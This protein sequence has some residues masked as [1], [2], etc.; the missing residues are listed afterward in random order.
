MCVGIHSYWSCLPQRLIKE[1]VSLA[2]AS[3]PHLELPV[4]FASVFFCELVHPPLE[5]Y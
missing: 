5:G 1:E 3:S 2:R 4:L